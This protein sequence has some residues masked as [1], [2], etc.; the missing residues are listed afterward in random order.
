MR[1]PGF[2]ECSSLRAHDRA[3]FV[4]LLIG[5]DFVVYRDGRALIFD[6]LVLSFVGHDKELSAFVRQL[7]DLRRDEFRGEIQ[8]D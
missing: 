2:P 5:S 8:N 6:I 3:G 1:T 7:P 4:S